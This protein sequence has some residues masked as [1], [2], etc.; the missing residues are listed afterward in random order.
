MCIRDRDGSFYKGKA[1]AK[2]NPPVIHGVKDIEIGVGEVDTFDKMDGITYTDDV[3]TTGLQISV[4]GEIG[5]PKAGT[6]E[7]YTLTYSVTDSDRN[8][9]TA[10]LSLIHI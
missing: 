10:D 1:P 5:K 9:A 6:N 8:T 3:D 4:T 7:D 2:S